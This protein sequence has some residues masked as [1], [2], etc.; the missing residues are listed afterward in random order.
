MKYL[1]GPRLDHAQE[2]MARA[3]PRATKLYD[4]TKERLTQEEAERIRL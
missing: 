4:W 2:I 3:S 1:Q